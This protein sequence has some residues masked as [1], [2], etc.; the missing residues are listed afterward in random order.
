MELSSEKIKNISE[1]EKLLFGGTTNGKYQDNSDACFA[2][3][4]R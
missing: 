2:Y 4:E 3:N 1:I